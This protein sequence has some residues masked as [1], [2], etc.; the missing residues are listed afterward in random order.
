M[1]Q[2]EIIYNVISF[3]I[4]VVMTVGFIFYGKK[5]L[6]KLASEEKGR[7]VNVLNFEYRNI[8]L[9][10]LPLHRPKDL[11]LHP[12]LQSPKIVSADFRIAN[13]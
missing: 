8:H 3:M 6:K 13:H 12:S 2:L 1:T 4:A 9:D 5:T 11:G 10:K 7:G